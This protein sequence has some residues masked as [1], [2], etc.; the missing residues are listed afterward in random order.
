MKGRSTVIALL[1]TAA[2][3]GVL[4]AQD[5]RVAG[6]AFLAHGNDGPDRVEFVMLAQKM[7]AA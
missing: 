4:G 2:S 1:L 5:F 7:V 6:I 3:A